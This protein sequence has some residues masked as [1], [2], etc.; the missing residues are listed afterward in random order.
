MSNFLLRQEETA[1]SLPFSRMF[2]YTL[3]EICRGCKIAELGREG[4]GGGEGSLERLH[5]R[6]KAWRAHR[7]IAI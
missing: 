2:E 1:H 3:S 4:G 5:I 6:S 7:K